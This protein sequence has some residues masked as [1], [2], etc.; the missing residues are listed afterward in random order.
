M[1]SNT[2]ATIYTFKRVETK[3][4]LTPEQYNAFMEVASEHLVPDAYFK[5]L[6]CSIYY[7]SD[8]YSLIRHSLEKPVYKEKLRIRSYGTARQ[9]SAA[10]VELK[11]KFKGVVY[12][13][14]VEM[15]VREAEEWL[16]GKGRPPKETQITKEIDWFLKMNDVSPKVFIGCDR[17]SYVDKDDSELRIT[18]D[19][20]IRWRETNLHLD[21]GDEGQEL[22]TDGKSLM[23]IKIPNAAPLWL[24]SLL[25]CENIFPTSYS[26]YGTCYKNEIV[27]RS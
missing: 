4:I 5:S 6:V 14:R 3:Y 17:T 19:S 25:S 27:R 23:E 8:D 12:K 26:K 15:T 13:R 21:A 20:Q 10:F 16:S 18:V 7:D 22:L 11:K 1:S 9:D 24:A 2:K